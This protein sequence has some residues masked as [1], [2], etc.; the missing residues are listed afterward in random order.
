MGLDHRCE[1]V[2]PSVQHHAPVRPLE[3][4]VVERRRHVVGDRAH[5]RRG[6]QIAACQMD[7]DRIQDSQDAPIDTVG[8]GMAK[9]VAAPAARI[10]DVPERRTDAGNVDSKQTALRL[11]GVS[12]EQARDIAMPVALELR[13]RVPGLF[14]VTVVAGAIKEERDPYLP[15]A[16]GTVPVAHASHCAGALRR[17]TATEA[18]LAIGRQFVWVLNGVHIHFPKFGWGLG[19]PG[20][21]V[22][23]SPLSG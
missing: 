4:E 2:F 9:G 16:S 22:A 12:V 23:S 10:A 20:R 1:F 11:V 17:F 13:L 15:L 6:D 3:A 19:T 14:P 18:A 5:L 21:K 7:V 8:P